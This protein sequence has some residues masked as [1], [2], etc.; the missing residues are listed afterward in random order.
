[1]LLC[2]N[3][4]G[5][6]E[7]DDPQQKD[8]A[9]HGTIHLIISN[10]LDTAS[11]A[12]TIFP[13]TPVFSSYRLSFTPLSGQDAKADIVISASGVT[14]IRDIDL[15]VGNWKITVYGR[16]LV[17]GLEK[18]VAEG[19]NDNVEVI[20]NED[21]IVSVTLHSKSP[22]S[23]TGTF[24]YSITVPQGI[25]ADSYSI[26]LSEWDNNTDRVFNINGSVDVS[27]ANFVITS[28]A[29]VLELIHSGYYLLEFSIGTSRQKALYVDI[30]HILTD[31]IS[32][33]ERIISSGDF[34][35]VI[36]L[37]G[38]VHA[39]I[40]T[41]GTSG[42]TDVK[43]V[44]AYSSEGEQIGYTTVDNNRWVMTIVEM[45]QPVDIFFRI[46]V[47]IPGDI[48]EVKSDVMRSVF[49][50]DI[51]GID[52]N[53]TFAV[54]TLKGTINST[55]FPDGI[56]D[57]ANWKVT[58][59][60]DPENI[61]GSSA[62]AVPAKTDSRGDWEMKIPAF[63][64]STDVYF[65]IED[66]SGRYKRINLNKTSLS[67]ENKDN[68]SITGYYFTPPKQVWVRVALPT[69]NGETEIVSKTMIKSAD[70]KKFT[71]THFGFEDVF[72]VI[73]FLT[74]FV[75]ADASPKWG[76]LNDAIWKYG[77]DNIVIAGTRPNNYQLGDSN[78]IKWWNI[79]ETQRFTLDFSGDD[80]FLT[81]KASLS[82][83]R[84]DE[85][86]NEILLQGGT[87]KMGSPVG[88]EGRLGP[89]GLSSEILHDVTISPVYMMNCEVTQK[90]YESLMTI[91]AYTAGFSNENYPVVN[92]SWLNACQFANALSAR[93]GYSS[94]YTISGTAVSADWNANGWRLPTESEWEYAAR[95]GSTTPFAI[96]GNFGNGNTLNT[97][98]ANY[99]GSAGIIAV[100]TFEPNAF[101]LYDMHGNAWEYCWDWYGEYPTAAV[102]DPKGPA[103]GNNGTHHADNPPPND[104]RIIRGGSYYC[105]ARYLR[106]AHRGTLA[107]NIASY[108]DIGFRLVRKAP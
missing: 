69:L 51:S 81:D 45:S 75:A 79:G 18:E 67:N 65:S 66:A 15:D 3:C 14:T 49:N 29:P 42:S 39:A 21:I 86:R 34:V 63:D 98:M 9:G 43:E 96:L 64:D 4:S 71:Y 103:T 85:K 60:T 76:G 27:A 28:S 99:N 54:I 7:H 40:N 106:S 26:V 12:R 2:N 87:F 83:E 25:A 6:F 33:F 32:R 105:A 59:Y 5:P 102:T 38:T 23:G 100:R 80:Y 89:S 108:N 90:I 24:A 16:A 82:I 92:I 77:Y 95:A 8:E 61:A 47:E 107:A 68:I 93:D 22:D 13:D 94:V 1:M 78:Q 46:R 72:H 41:A 20:A 36:M 48:I 19:S 70:G 104:V 91:P 74:Y 17:N 44:L 11:S 56:T 62:N 97:T 58:V 50:S 53:T 52:I 57:K 101:G 73:S 10:P 31:R 84:L 55:Y 30:V 88:E 37:S 35:P